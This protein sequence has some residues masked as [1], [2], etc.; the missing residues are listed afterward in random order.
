MSGRK[1]MQSRRTGTYEDVQIPVVARSGRYQDGTVRILANNP[2]PRSARPNRGF[3]EIEHM[4]IASQSCS[5]Q[6]GSW[7]IQR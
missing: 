5:E 6:Y 3:T 7:Q 2:L 4:R 1:R